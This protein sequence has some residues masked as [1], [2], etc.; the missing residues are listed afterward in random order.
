MASTLRR[1]GRPERFVWLAALAFALALPLMVLLR[2]PATGGVPSGPSP[3]PAATGVIGLPT[4][5]V[6]P[7]AGA[8]VPFGT[9]LVGA[10]LL[11]SALLLSRLGVAAVRLVWA[12]RAWRPTL[13]DGTSVW[14]TERLGPAVAG[15]VRPRVLVPEWITTMPAHRRALVLLHEQEHIRAGDPW[16]VATSRLAPI[17]APWNPAIW[18]LA[19]RLLRAVELDCDRRVL[20][21]RP[22]VRTYGTTLLEVSSRDSRRLVAVA[23]F[24]ES[25]A[26][27]RGRILNMTTPP[28][29]VSVVALLTSMVL[30][31]ALIGVAFQVP[32]P[33][34]GPRGEPGASTEEDFAR[35]FQVVRGREV[36]PEPAPRPVQPQR[37]VIQEEQQEEQVEPTEPEATTGRPIEEAVPTSRVRGDLSSEPT[38]TPFTAA[39]SLMNIAEVQRALVDAYPAGL[40]DEG[41][42][43]TVTVWFFID[44][45]GRVTHTRIDM[46]SGLPE[47][48][49]A[50]LE[51]ADVMRFSPARNREERVPVWV[52]LPVTFQIR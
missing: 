23:A 44:E 12:G 4:V 48:D 10:W 3:E 5:L 14:M 29:T 27:L 49:R 51:V 6:V 16:L 22:D 34:V 2:P 1:H 33:A 37:P 25:E 31:I 40:R 39:P 15:L 28:R 30:G 50:A 13:L 20:R 45:D 9:V 24:A 17:V 26:P 36:V 46:S 35:T 11:A 42:G 52:S 41:T 8:E 32:V 43:G 21:Q 47:L 7:D 18:L 38:F 19:S